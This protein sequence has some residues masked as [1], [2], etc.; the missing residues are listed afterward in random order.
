MKRQFPAPSFW[1][2]AALFAS[3]TLGCGNNDRYNQGYSNGAYA[4]ANQAVT[5]QN[6]LLNAESFNLETVVGLIRSGQA[7]DAASLQTRINDRAS[8]INNVDVDH[9]NM[10]DMIVVRETDTNGNKSFDFVAQP[11]G[12]PNGEPVTVATASFVQQNGQVM[13][14]AG[15]PQYVQGY[16]DHYYSLALARDIAF[17]SWLYAPRPLYVPLYSY[18]AYG[19]HAYPLLAPSVLTS[20]RTNYRTT[21]NV[22]PI[23]TSAR[24]Q[25]FASSARVPSAYQGQMYRA[26]VSSNLGARAGAAR[27]FA[28]AAPNVNQRRVTA[29]GSAPTTQPTGWAPRPVQN[30]ARTTPSVNVSAPPVWNRPVAPATNWRPAPS[31]PSPV[32]RAPA[33]TYRAPSAPS[34]GGW[35]RPSTPV[36]RSGG[37]GGGAF[38][39]RR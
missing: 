34:G 12:N 5:T 36:F 19:Y 39:R 25:T 1:L 29:F 17:M 37:G 7:T 13:V 4:P 26:P 35:G 32:Y 20:T 2:M 28:V 22:T 6:F 38:G 24:P 23:A 14:Q 27:P 16:H 10:V 11:S 15:Y 31:A 18:G 8:A 9:D 3:V 33:P 30:Q 21:T